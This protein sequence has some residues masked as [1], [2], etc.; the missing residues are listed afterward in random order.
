MC[1]S[2]KFLPPVFMKIRQDFVF[3]LRLIERLDQ[4]LARSCLYMR[5]GSLTF[6]LLK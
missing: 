3:A 5:A 4:P 6:Y 1:N 2:P